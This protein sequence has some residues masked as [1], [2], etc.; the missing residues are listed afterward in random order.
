[1]GTEYVWKWGLQV[2]CFLCLTGFYVPTLHTRKSGKFLLNTPWANVRPCSKHQ[3]KFLFFCTRGTIMA[4][5]YIWKLG[6]RKKKVNLAIIS[7]RLAQ[8]QV[9]TEWLTQAQDQTES[10]YCHFPTCIHAPLHHHQLTMH[11]TDTANWGCEQELAKGWI[12]GYNCLCHC[13]DCVWAGSMLG[14]TAWVLCALHTLWIRHWCC[15][16]QLCHT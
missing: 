16:D 12:S 13:W 14:I 9:I 6:F 1:M 11:Y 4:Y 5:E 10:L 7:P 2:N 15:G 3:R 8:V